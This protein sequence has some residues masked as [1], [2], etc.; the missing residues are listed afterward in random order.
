[1]Q[2]QQVMTCQ[3]DFRDVPHVYRMDR[4]PS[5]ITFAVD[6]LVTGRVERG[7]L[8]AAIFDNPLY[9]VF[10]LAVGGAWPG[11]PASDTFWPM[12]MSVDWVRVSA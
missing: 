9:I 12:V 2:N 8:P 7:A 10:N 6:G 4:S 1:M 3:S 5:G 11:P